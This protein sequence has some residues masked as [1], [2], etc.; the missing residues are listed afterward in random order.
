MLTLMPT[1]ICRRRCKTPGFLNMSLCLRRCVAGSKWDCVS[2][3][4]RRC[5]HR[6]ALKVFCFGALRSLLLL[7]AEAGVLASSGSD[8]H[9][10]LDQL[11]VE[12][13]VAGMRIG[14]PKADT[15]VLTLKREFP[16]QVGEESPSRMEEFNYFRVLFMSG[17]RDWQKDCSS[18]SGDAE[19]FLVCCG[20]ER[21]EHE[22]RAL[23][24]SSP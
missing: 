19:V 21:P 24:L 2:F 9:L 8:L 1:V 16:L 12:R 4:D 3:M 22:S 20:K 15:M 10:A 5:R 14:T 7:F 23:F 6:Q 17:A 11:T 18:V 13:E